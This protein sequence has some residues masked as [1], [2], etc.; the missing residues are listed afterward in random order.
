V[1][2]EST[3]KMRDN[4]SVLLTE[5]LSGLE[6][7]LGKNESEN[8]NNSLGFFDDLN[9]FKRKYFEFFFS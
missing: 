8:S 1:R 5:S 7:K 6:G 4:S 9:D 3:P 2:E